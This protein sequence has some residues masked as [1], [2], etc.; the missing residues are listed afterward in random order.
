MA[1]KRTTRRPRLDP[2]PPGQRP[3]RDDRGFYADQFNASE[4][5]L[6]AAA[7][8]DP[9][10]DDEVWAMRVLNRRLLAH[11]TELEAEGG[12]LPIESLVKVAD[13]LTAGT[14]R[15]ARLLR[16]RQALSGQAADLNAASALAAVL[17]DILTQMGWEK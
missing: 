3:A 2:Q 7:A 9:V 6:M 5:A 16:D 17:D 13:A 10:L 14:G 11:V 8:S 12:D 1:R 15:V 4:L